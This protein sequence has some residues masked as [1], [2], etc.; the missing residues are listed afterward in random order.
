MPVL[1]ERRR[2]RADFKDSK[3]AVF[4][5]HSFSLTAQ[6]FG[7]S[8]TILNKKYLLYITRFSKLKN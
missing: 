8:I 3:K 1:A 7:P 5:N 4:F 6:L 2:A